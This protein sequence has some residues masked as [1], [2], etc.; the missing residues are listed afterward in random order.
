MHVRHPDEPP[1]VEGIKPPKVVAGSATTHPHLL[2]FPDAKRHK[3]YDET[4]FSP[5]VY[6]SH[7]YCA[8]GPAHAKGPARR[9]ATGKDEPLSLRYAHIERTTP[10]TLRSTPEGKEPSGERTHLMNYIP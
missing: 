6:L 10:P 5:A 3:T 9:Q 7:R 8:C 1:T 2:H 4:L